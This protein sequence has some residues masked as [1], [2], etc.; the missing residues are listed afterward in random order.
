MH[1][2][3]KWAYSPGMSPYPA[4]QCPPMPPDSVYFCR[5]TRYHELEGSKPTLASNSSGL[6]FDTAP[7]T[8]SVI[9]RT[10]HV[11][12]QNLRNGNNPM[13]TI[14]SAVSIIGPPAIDAMIPTGSTHHGMIH[15]KILR[16]S[17]NRLVP[18]PTSS[19]KNHPNMMHCMNGALAL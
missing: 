5:P 10:K 13:I 18:S 1:K 6:R 8:A 16:F 14:A 3:W 2:S 15:G 7:M 4:I 9:A 11:G 17:Q 12:F 19:A